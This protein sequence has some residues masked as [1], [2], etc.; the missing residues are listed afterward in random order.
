MPGG[1]Q[2]AG[3]LH[4]HGGTA[5]GGGVEPASDGSPSEADA[6]QKEVPQAGRNESF[7]RGVPQSTLSRTEADRGEV[8]ADDVC[9][10]ARCGDAAEELQAE[11]ET[12]SLGNGG[13]GFVWQCHPRLRTDLEAAAHTV[14]LPQDGC[15]AGRTPLTVQP[16]PGTAIEGDVYV[17]PFAAAAQDRPRVADDHAGEGFEI[18]SGDE[19]RP[20]CA[21]GPASAHLPMSVGMN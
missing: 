17:G 12:P 1:G 10:S 2:V 3:P 15:S 19:G 6:A 4:R 13:P 8:V 5:V 21:A 18:T 11:A 9:S 14:P 16:R 7:M 20:H